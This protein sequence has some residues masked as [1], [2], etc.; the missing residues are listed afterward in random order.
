MSLYDNPSEFASELRNK[1]QKYGPVI[2]GDTFEDMSVT[3]GSHR[4]V[5]DY[6]LMIQGGLSGDRNFFNIHR[7]TYEE[8]YP[9]LFQLSDNI[10]PELP[11][12][13]NSSELIK[14]DY[15]ITGTTVDFSSSTFIPI[16]CIDKSM[17]R[18][19]ENKGIRS[20][21]DIAFECFM[22]THVCRNVHSNTKH[23]TKYDISSFF[24]AMLHAVSIKSGKYHNAWRMN[25]SNN[26]KKIGDVTSFE[27]RIGDLT[28]KQRKMKETALAEFE[29]HSVAVIKAKEIQ[30]QKR[31][32]TIFDGLRPANGL[33][34]YHNAKDRGLLF[35]L[36]Y[37]FCH[38]VNAQSEGLPMI[39]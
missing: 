29:N 36:V 38:M 34:A 4:N 16:N 12:F 8:I 22:V 39:V 25:D 32:K 28:A 10:L 37:L 21:I 6:T 13:A 18:K 35:S 17:V 1:I 24:T 19:E 27:F 11:S 15:R 9:N 23:S 3:V 30:G 31:N 7:D 5:D 14:M 2:Y 20:L 33:N 26:A